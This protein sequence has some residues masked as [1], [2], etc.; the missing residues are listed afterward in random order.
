MS[1]GTNGLFIFIEQGTPPTLGD[2]FDA[3]LHS[4]CTFQG[5]LLR[6]NGDSPTDWV[7]AVDTQWLG[8][9]VPNGA[10]FQAN[11]TFENGIQIVG[12]T[13]TNLGHEEGPNSI[14]ALSVGMEFDGS[15]LMLGF[16][17]KQPTPRGGA[18][19]DAAG[20]GTV[21]TEAR[22]AIN[23]LLAE[24]RTKGFIPFA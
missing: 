11:A 20:G 12:G 1:N 14:S 19:P 17:H 7:P 13:Y 24:L 21:D 6:K 10:V 22:A 3:P 4:I 23:G 2:G 15:Q 8:G 18:I 5:Q 9:T 16:F